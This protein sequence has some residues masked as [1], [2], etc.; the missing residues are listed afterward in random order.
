MLLL[1]QEAECEKLRMDAKYAADTKIADSARM[2][3]MQKAGFDIEV[4]A[5]VSLPYP[6]FLQNHF[7]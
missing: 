2:F 3:Q 5:S 1:L 4:N 6:Y 7:Q